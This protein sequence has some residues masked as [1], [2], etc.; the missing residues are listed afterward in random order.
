MQ[1]DVGR[2][3]RSSPL[4]DDI[5]ADTPHNNSKLQ[6][7]T[8]FVS[9]RCFLFRIHPRTDTDQHKLFLHSTKPDSLNKGLVRNDITNVLHPSAQRFSGPRLLGTAIS[10]KIV[11]EA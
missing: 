9:C 1:P 10:N 7:T 5:E 3:G 8:S 11:K 6:N 4:A 2:Q